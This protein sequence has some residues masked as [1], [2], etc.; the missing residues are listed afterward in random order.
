MATMV[1]FHAHPDDEAIST[2]GTMALAAAR[3]HRV[4]LVVAT[5]GEEGEVD[6]GFLSTGE[7]LGERRTSELMASASI[8]GVDRVEFLG[9][10]DSGMMGTRENAEPAC[11]WQADVGEVAA[12]LASI[13]DSEAAG[14][15]TIYD[16]HGGYGHPDHI[17]V[18]R[19]GALA[20]EQAGTE[21]LYEA[22]MNRDR[23]RA[24]R[25]SA[26][27][28]DPGAT[29]AFYET[30]GTQ[31]EEITTAVDVRSV[32]ATK[33]FA[34]AA[35][36]SQIGPKSWFMQLAPDDFEEAF[37]TEWFVRARPPFDGT[38]PGHREGFLV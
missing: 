9:Y 7:T 22:T 2:G 29:D 12:L 13:L 34:M 26:D 25:A 33:R 3:G 4:V 24:R 18:H 32:L 38:G 27:D 17:Q 11:F 37:G 5:R 8:L 19:V 35:H 14:V 31:D 20:G 1:F 21:R 30:I 6:D 28:D 15:L 10:R 23:I 16:D 36:A